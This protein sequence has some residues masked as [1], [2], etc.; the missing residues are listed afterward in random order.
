MHLTSR[1]RAN[2]DARHRLD[3][4]LA[5][6]RRHPQ[7]KGLTFGERVRV[8]KFYDRREALESTTTNSRVFT[9]D[10]STSSRAVI[11]SHTAS[12]VRGILIFLDSSS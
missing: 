8:G 10:Y 9:H 12:M 3:R 2:A 6:F 1:S 4:A 7:P 5:L 11:R